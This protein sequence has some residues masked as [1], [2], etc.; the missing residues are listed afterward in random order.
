MVLCKDSRGVC[1]WVSKK[2]SPYFF[3]VITLCL[4]PHIFISYIMSAV[5]C[6]GGVLF[7][8]ARKKREPKTQTTKTTPGRRRRKTNG[9][10]PGE[11]VE[12][13]VRDVEKHLMRKMNAMTTTSPD[14]SS[15][16]KRDVG[17]V[18]W[19]TTFREEV[20]KRLK[21]VADEARKT[22]T[23]PSRAFTGWLREEKRDFRATDDTSA[24]LERCEGI[25]DY[26]YD[27]DDTTPTR[28]LPSPNEANVR[29]LFADQEEES[30]CVLLVPG[31]WG[32]H[33]PGYYSTVRDAFRTI[34]GVECEISRVNS[35]GTVRETRKLLQMKLK[36]C[37]MRRRRNEL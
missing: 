3:C 4:C 11:R 24:F 10:N 9:R 5:R 35:E 15:R 6:L 14:A 12:R 31:L 1:V 34:L 29:A 16:G 27:D 17:G 33:Y 37:G 18:A 7:L 20:E 23:K 22:N 28:G 36:R 30:F 19:T 32:H 25:V 8:S 2:R 13:L 21:R 26:D